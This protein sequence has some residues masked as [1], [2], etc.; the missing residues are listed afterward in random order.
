MPVLPELFLSIFGD[1]ISF[2]P[3]LHVTATGV[4]QG[5]VEAG[6]NWR[7]FDFTSLILSIIIFNLQ[8]K[9]LEFLNDD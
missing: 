8:V 1:S 6:S 9:S 5:R 2:A 3:A 7:S 4:P